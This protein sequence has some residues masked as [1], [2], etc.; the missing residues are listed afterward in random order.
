MK[1]IRLEA[2]N[3]KKLIAVAIEPNGHVVEITGS[4]GAGKTSTLDAIWALVGGKDAVPDK[5]IR[6]GQQQAVISAVLGDGTEAK[7]KV[8]RKFRLK[9]GVAYST[10]LIVESAEGARFG[11]PQGI[12]DGLVGSLC[13]DPLAFTRMKDEEQIKA[14][15]AFVPEV[16]FAKVEGLNR[17]DYDERTEVNRRARELRALAN[18]LPEFAGDVPEKVDVAALEEKLGA[19]AAHNGDVERRKAARKGAEDR[20][21][22]IN[23][24]IADLQAEAAELQR[25]LDGAPALPEPMDIDGIRA[26]LA[27]GRRDNAMAEQAAQRQDL[28]DR[29]KANEERSVELTHAIEQRTADME[30][31]VESAKMPVRGLGFGQ[32]FVTLNGEPFAQASQAEKIRASVAIAAAMN[33]KLRVAR[34]LDGSLLDARSWDALVTYAAEA[35][36]QIW[37]ETISAHGP[38]AVHIEDGGIVGAPAAESVDEDVV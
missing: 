25:K 17:A 19:A 2:S 4:N 1:I 22:A 34:V 38:A 14:L 6:S 20:I 16:D 37:A 5:P 26:A 30:K 24:Q 8:T 15:R 7:L 29:A 36:L 32:G 31:A 21:G 11:S 3:F 12:L 10:D 18:A 9:E 23:R 28:I 35:D 33:P 27:E 13:F